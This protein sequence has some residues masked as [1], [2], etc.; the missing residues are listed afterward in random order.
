MVLGS[1]KILQEDNNMGL[2]HE[3]GYTREM[4]LRSVGDGW[5]NG[6]NLLFDAK[7]DDVVV[8]QVKEK[9]GG[10]RFY[11]SNSTREY[12]QLIRYVES[13]CDMLCENCGKMGHRTKGGWIKTLCDDCDTDKN[14]TKNVAKEED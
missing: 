6:I 9:F 3:E 4:A 12:Q 13:L 2:V 1:F 11:T 5:S 10:L 14:K 7:P 8:V